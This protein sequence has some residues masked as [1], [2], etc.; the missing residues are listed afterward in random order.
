MSSQS[1]SHRTAT[2]RPS[3]LLKTGLL[4]ILLIVAGAAAPGL[5]SAETKTADEEKR[6][7]SRAALERRVRELEARLAELEARIARLRAEGREVGSA[8]LADLEKRIRALTLEI[9]RL[10][11]GEAA[12][13]AAGESVHGFGPAASKVY[14][15]GKG[16]AI[17]G[18][19]EL[20]YRNFDDEDDAGAPSGSIDE[21]DF[22]RAVFYFGYKFNDRLLFNSE[23]EFEHA[24]A[25]E[26]KGGE[27][28]VEFAYVDYK[29]TDRFGARGGLLL[30]PLGFINE[31]HE[32]PIFHGANR[33]DVERFII[34]ATW[35]ENGAGVYGDAG[36]IAYRAYVTTG[37]EGIG[38]SGDG[39]IRGGRQSGSKAIAEDLAVTARVDYTPTPGLLVGASA[40]SGGVGQGVAGIGGSRLT[41]WDLHAE[42]NWRGLHVRGLFARGI[43]SG[44]REVGSAID[45]IKMVA[46]G[47]TVIGERQ[48]GWYGEIA[49]NVLARAGGTEQELSP[50]FRYEDLNTQEEVP[51]GLIA[52]PA[53]DRRV[54]V[55]GITYRPIPNV[56]VKLDLQN[57]LNGAGTAVDQW[58]LALGYLF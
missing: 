5:R 51:A 34:P 49:W 14:A 21:A 28:A 3:H 19:G 23:I 46:P 22:L 43:L 57:R 31:L 9:E 50:F 18:Y 32:P 48:Q 10:R 25:G 56:A 40:F 15:T 8:D 33:P 58:N 26:G 44:A 4:L 20:L 55:Y 39:G 12:A 30:V 36:P 27:V 2:R 41:L 52:D 54:R 17:G 45:A 11:I 53:N 35:R 42:W 24:Q 38:F 1:G 37:L 6:E 29:A 13:P 16:V 7:E 47:T